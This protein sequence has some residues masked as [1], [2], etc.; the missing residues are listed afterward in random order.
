MNTNTLFLIRY[1]FEGKILALLTSDP[2]GTMDEIFSY[3]PTA[4][5]LEVL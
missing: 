4:Q 3:L 1:T 2:F 5:I